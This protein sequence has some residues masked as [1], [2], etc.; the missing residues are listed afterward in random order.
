MLVGVFFKVRFWD[1]NAVFPLFCLRGLCIDAVCHW[2][3]HTY[4]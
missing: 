4:V 2:C 1:D 3:D